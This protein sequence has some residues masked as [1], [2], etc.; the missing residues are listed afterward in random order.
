M[1]D[2]A[3]EGFE[4]RTLFRVIGENGFQNGAARPQFR[5][6]PERLLN[7]LRRPHDVLNLAC[8]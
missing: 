5:L 3:G 7:D 8:K 2:G 1:C 4:I 6:Q